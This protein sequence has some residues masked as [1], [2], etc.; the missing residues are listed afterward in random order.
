MLIELRLVVFVQGPSAKGAIE[1]CAPERF[2][3]VV[4]EALNVAGG[5]FLRLG[6]QFVKS[7]GG[8]G[9]QVLVVDQH[10]VVAVVVG[11]APLRAAYNGR[12]QRAFK[13]LVEERVVEQLIDSLHVY[14]IASSVAA[15]KMWKESISNATTAC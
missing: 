6:D 15:S 8:F 3:Q 11:D 13:E 10:E 9:D 2:V 4:S 1:A 7:G 12:S 14:R 5:E